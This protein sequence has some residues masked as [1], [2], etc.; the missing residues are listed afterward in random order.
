[1]N[2]PREDNKSKRKG[3]VFRI[4]TNLSYF[5]QFEAAVK[6]FE[7]FSVEEKIRKNFFLA[8]I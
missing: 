1:M 2:T 6:N 4:K 8:T 7:I 3:S 5:R